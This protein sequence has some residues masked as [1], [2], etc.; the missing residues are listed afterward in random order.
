M[1][2]NIVIY[3]TLYNVTKVTM[4]TFNHARI[5]LILSFYVATMVTKSM[6]TQGKKDYITL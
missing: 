5:V 1:I 6:M 4:T 3:V 2:N